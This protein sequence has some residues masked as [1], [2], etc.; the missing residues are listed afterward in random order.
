MVFNSENM[1]VNVPDQASFWPTTSKKSD[2]LT[3]EMSE[4]QLGGLA[5]IEEGEDTQASLAPPPVRK[6]PSKQASKQASKRSST[7]ASGAPPSQQDSSRSQQAPGEGEDAP[8]A[9]DDVAQPAQEEPEAQGGDAAAPDASLPAEDPGAGGADDAAA[10]AEEYASDHD[11]EEVEVERGGELPLGGEEAA[12][13]EAEEETHQESG[14][15]QAPVE[16]VEE[17][18]ASLEVPEA[19]A[20]AEGLP[21]VRGVVEMH[22]QAS[23]TVCV[24]ANSIRRD[25]CMMSLY[26]TAGE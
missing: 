10:T 22:G 9:P 25:E 21:Q 4:E 23:V 16:G 14:Q 7:S 12:P 17:L 18:G 2:V 8:S 19:D 3:V 5:A 13:V 6:Q 26:A 15:E 1:P 24:R 20:P 11:P